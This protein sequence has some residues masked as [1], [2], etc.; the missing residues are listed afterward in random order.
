V[1]LEQDQQSEEWVKQNNGG[2][3]VTPTLD[4]LG[5]ILVNPDE[6]EL[7]TCMREKHLMG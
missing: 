7:E 5:S 4:V 2:K 1:D 6:C 3:R